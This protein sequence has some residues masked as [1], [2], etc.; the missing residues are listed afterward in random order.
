MTHALGVISLA[1]TGRGGSVAILPKA[2]PKT[3]LDAITRYRVTELFLAPTVIYRADGD[4]GSHRVGPL[5]PSLPALCRGADVHREAPACDRGYWPVMVECYG[6]VEAF[7]G[8]SFMCPEEHYSD[9]QVAPDSRLA[10]CDRPYPLVNVEIHNGAGN[11]WRRANP[12]RSAWV[13]WP[14]IENGANVLLRTILAIA[15]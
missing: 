13:H 12:G 2:E 10:A 15:G 4:T 8:S 14:D 9:G 1:G 7:C 11:R 3:V 6:Q 5:V